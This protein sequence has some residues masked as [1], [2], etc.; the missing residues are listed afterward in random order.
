MILSVKSD[1]LA[2]AKGL[3]RHGNSGS[4]ILPV[5]YNCIGTIAYLINSLI[6]SLIRL[7]DASD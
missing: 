1:S 5:N 2:K 6:K 4:L 3:D 7:V